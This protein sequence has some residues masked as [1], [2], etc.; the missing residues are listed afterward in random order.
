M[1]DNLN[2]EYAPIAGEAAFQQA[3]IKYDYVGLVA[4]ISS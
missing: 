3:A 4:Q 1:R 2:K